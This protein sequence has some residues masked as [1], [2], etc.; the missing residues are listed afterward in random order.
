MRVELNRVHFP[1][2]TLGYGRRVGVW[3]QGCSIRCSGCVSRDTWEEDATRSISVAELIVSLHPWLTAAD[4]VTIS[5][6]EPFDQPDGLAALLAAFGDE[7]PSLDLLVYSGYEREMLHENH[8]EILNRIDVLISGPY[9]PAS[10]TRLALRGSDNQHVEL[11]TSR[12]CGRYPADLDQRPASRRRLDAAFDGRDLWMAGIP[13]RGDLPR[14]QRR[15][16]EHGYESSHSQEQR[17]E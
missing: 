6:G 9:Q 10:G 16:S 8:G 7:H 2:T 1:V 14:F 3:F 17:E 11:L 5:G 13:A 12:A 15:L 4:G